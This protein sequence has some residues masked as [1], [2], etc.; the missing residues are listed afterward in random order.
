M[1]EPESTATLAGAVH[2]ASMA[3]VLGLGCSAPSA[4]VDELVTATP[5]GGGASRTDTAGPDSDWLGGYLL[6]TPLIASDGSIF[7]DRY[8]PAETGWFDPATHTYHGMQ[9]GTVRSFGVAADALAVAEIDHGDCT[10]EIVT[11]SGT[12]LTSLGGPGNLTYG[13]ELRMRM[14][15][16][17]PPTFAFTSHDTT[18]A[19]VSSFT[20]GDPGLVGIATP[21]GA[22]DVRDLHDS[23]RYG[24]AELPL[25]AAGS[26]TEYIGVAR[27][28]TV[29]VLPFEGCTT[30][31]ATV[32]QTTGATLVIDGELPDTNR[33]I[34]A[35]SHNQII[36]VATE[37]TNA[38]AVDVFGGA[39]PVVRSL[40]AS[41]SPLPYDAW[42]LGAQGPTRLATSMGNLAVSTTGTTAHVV[43]LTPGTNGFYNIVLVRY[44]DG[45]PVQQLT[46]ATQV[47]DNTAPQVVT[48]PEGA[49]LVSG[50][51]QA[52]VV[53]S[54]SFTATPLDIATIVGGVRGTATVIIGYA[55]STTATAGQLY[56]YDEL[57]GSPHLTP[58]SSSMTNPRIAMVDPPEGPP[59]TWFAYMSDGG[60]C[61]LAQVGLSGGAPALQHQ[62]PW[63]DT[64]GIKTWGRTPEGKLLVWAQGSANTYVAY[65][66][67]DDS[68][69]KVVDATAA[70]P[71]DMAG[72]VMDTSVSPP[73]VV[74]WYGGDGVDGF[75]CLAR[76]PERCWKVPTS[77]PVTMS[78]YSSGAAADNDSFA[79]GWY[80]A[81]N[82]ADAA[83]HAVFLHAIGSGDRPQPL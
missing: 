18:G 47:F 70:Q 50:A 25:C 36:H 21:S 27:P 16:G 29:A 77:L 2:G 55:K 37:L 5:L 65:L 38:I 41:G 60:G 43:G 49:A 80:P 66:L 12:Q 1:H 9:S 74:G 54:T 52:W 75:A 39:V 20:A 44:R 26:V 32:D 10:F 45:Q 11:P 42:A 19:Y 46:L 82:G 78:A 23:L 59:S 58:L 6:G 48:T 4:C 69:T 24:F 76:H 34:V 83:S 57:G 33:A 13:P 79:L 53:P 56:T 14:S 81:G 72:A 7:V 3:A 30:L 67:G 17:D 22:T 71:L 62:V 40:E 28:G 51:Q 68:A 8:S 73:V 61:M 63:T 15:V 64:L 35:I 31:R